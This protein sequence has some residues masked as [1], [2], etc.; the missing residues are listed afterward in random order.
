MA[1]FP[2][3][4]RVWIPGIVGGAQT[5]VFGLVP[6]LVLR[7]GFHWALSWQFLPSVMGFS[8]QPLL[9]LFPSEVNQSM[10]S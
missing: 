4:V 1:C 8:R 10:F 2:H 5:P 7:V 6:V 9:K 3:I